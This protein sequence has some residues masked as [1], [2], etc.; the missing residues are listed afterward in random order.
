MTDEGE[1]SGIEV[2]LVEEFAETLDADVTWVEGGEEKLFTDLAAGRLDMV[3]GG[4]TDTTP[5]TDKAAITQ[6]FD[7]VTTS[8]GKT[9]KHVMAAAMGENAFLVELEQFLLKQETAP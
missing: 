3:V 7:Q 8:D 1:A 5:W 4:L 9:V 2:E 6:P